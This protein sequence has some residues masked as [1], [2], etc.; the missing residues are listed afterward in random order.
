ME[1]RAKRNFNVSSKL[2]NMELQVELL[3]WSKGLNTNSSKQIKEIKIEMK[4]LKRNGGD[5][6][7]QYWAHLKMRLHEAYK[8]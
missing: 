3:K 6:D 7:W 1:L 5:R 4:D 2:Q 8:N